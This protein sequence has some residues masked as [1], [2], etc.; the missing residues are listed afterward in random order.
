MKKLVILLF[1]A[2]LS[3]AQ[4][5]IKISL[6]GDSNTEQAAKLEII[7]IIQE[8][9]QKLTVAEMNSRLIV[10]K[11]VLNYYK[12]EEILKMHKE[13]YAYRSKFVTIAGNLEKANPGFSASAGGG[14]SWKYIQQLSGALS[15]ADGIKQ[16]LD[17]VTTSGKMIE[18]PA[19]PTFEIS[20]SGGDPAGDV[21]A[22]IEAALAEAGISSQEDWN[23]L[24]KDQQDA[25]SQKISAYNQEFFDGLKKATQDGNKQVV[26]IVGNV[27]GSMFGVPNAGSMLVGLASGGGAKALSGLVGYFVD[28]F[29]VPTEYYSAPTLKLT[30]SER[31][32]IIDELHLRISE[33]YQQTT[34]LGAS[35]SLEVKKR[36][37]EISQPRN[38]VILYGP[39]K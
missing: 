13:M 15:K 22:K 5:D 39:K 34:A 7:R 2:Q 14:M 4:N 16:Q 8:R 9:M 35:M 37:D 20:P 21:K 26:S 25:L 1:A 18:L 32:R 30:D 29:Q 6:K 31:I 3:F 10:S 33:L 38:E 28:N 12:V 36:Y 27:V 17:L 23:K 11:G 19:L 24:T